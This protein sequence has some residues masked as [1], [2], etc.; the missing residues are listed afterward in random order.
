MLIR[1]GHVVHREVARGRAIKT[2]FGT[3][4]TRH[5]VFTVL[6]D[7]AGRRGIGE[8]WVNFP[9]WAPYERQAAFEQVF[10][11]AIKGR[12]VE[13]IPAFIGE[14]C[15]AFLGASRQSGTIGPLL[16]ILCAVELALWDL[17]AR[18][19][20]VP[21]CDLLFDDARKDI[22][23]YA[24]G[25]NSPIPWDLIDDM[26]SKGVRLFKLKLGFDDNEDRTALDALARHLKGKARLAVDIN[27]AWTLEQAL[28]WQSTL[29]SHDVQWLE[30]PLRI[31]DE[32]R[33]DELH[34]AARVPIAGGENTLFL[35]GESVEAIADLSLDIFQPD[36]T[37]YCPLHKALELIDAV[38]GRNR[39]T[40]PHFLGS[41][42][43]QAASIHLAAGCGALVEYDINPNR[44]RTDL[45]DEPFDIRDGRIHIPDRPGLSWSWP[46]E[47]PS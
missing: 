46:N 47:E 6:E 5:I 38:N 44:L 23:I 25:I 26:V 31:Q 28:E 19:R 17:Q 35:P 33:L 45:L 32:H 29:E 18:E 36:I 30:E 39:R 4:T 8:S 43:G 20:G 34:S 37:K 27:R 15:S 21:L 14:L 22:E 40:I 10:L 41:A 12:T 24:S 1:D 11:P 2:A 16:Q 42:P 3:M 13:D 7:D 9:A